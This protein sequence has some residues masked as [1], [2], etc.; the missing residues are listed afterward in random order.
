MFFADDIILCGN[1]RHLTE[2]LQVVSTFAD[3]N[4]IEFS[5]PKSVV[6][7]FGRN[8]ARC[9]D[10]WDLGHVPQEGSEH[11]YVQM[12]TAKKGK[13]LGVDYTS[14][15]NIFQAHYET[16]VTKAQRSA[17]V[18]ALL[19][20]DVNY[21]IQLMAKVWNLYAVPTCMYGMEVI[22]FTG[23][24]LQKLERV[25]KGFVK[26][27]LGLPVSTSN[28][29]VYMLSG[30]QQLS[31]VAHKHKANYFR[32]VYY[33]SP[34]RWVHKAYLEQ[35]S[36][37]ISDGVI[38]HN[39]NIL[40]T[41]VRGTK[42]WLLDVCNALSKWELTRLVPVAKN[43]VKQLCVR[44]QW[45]YVLDQ[46]TTHSSVK[47]MDEMMW[48][49][50]NEYHC[51]RH[52]W[53]LRGR[54]GSLLLNAKLEHAVHGKNCPACGQEEETLDHFL[55][56]HQYISTLHEE[57]YFMLYDYQWWF[58]WHRSDGE[59]SR[60]SRYIGQRWAERK[61]NFVEPQQEH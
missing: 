35:R 10:T 42:Y 45:D 24:Q 2:I 14:S 4:K 27:V 6:M 22:H 53:W 32:Y 29:A 34:S 5:G 56:C 37:L 55:S 51:R 16:M 1:E 3:R 58:S 25:Q 61:K 21:P 57:W 11:L 54:A 12:S 50:D 15:K 48:E 47:F 23:V 28:A 30:L 44:T 8:I 43:D 36:W 33:T 20:K 60:I 41:D 40:T 7:A 59:R 9:P 52:Y 49:L 39:E 13:Y 26:R 17:G 38:D 18:L 46:I 19:L 31:V